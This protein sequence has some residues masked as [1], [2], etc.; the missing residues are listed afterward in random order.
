MSEKGHFKIEYIKFIW[1]GI[2]FLFGVGYIINNYNKI[3]IDANMIDKMII[4][5]TAILAFFPI[6]SEISLMGFSLRKELQTTKQEFRDE[7]FDLKT[8]I[9]LNMSQANSQSVNLTLLSPKEKLEDLFESSKES[10]VSGNMGKEYDSTIKDIKIK[11]GMKNDKKEVEDKREDEKVNNRAYH[12]SDDAIYLFTIRY[13]IEKLIDDIIHANDYD[14][15][16]SIL[17]KIE[18]LRNQKCINIKTYESI[19]EILNICNRGI[20]GEI[21]DKYYIDF[22]RNM[23]P[24]VIASLNNI[25]K[26]N[27]PLYFYT[28]SKCH[29][30]GYSEVE[31]VCPQCKYVTDEY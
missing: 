9:Y 7:L 8:K 20:H 19:R 3:S 13:S 25:S 27:K 10:E 14:Y 11:S 16:G 28:C 30:E 23:M 18:T 4:G 15:S 22:V 5:G 24:Y 6:V 26:N 12:P 1:G 31:N 2:L 17:R 29:Y 21:V